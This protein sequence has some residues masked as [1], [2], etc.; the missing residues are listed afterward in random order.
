MSAHCPEEGSKERGRN[1]DVTV[2]HKMTHSLG[3]LIWCLACLRSCIHFQTRR[4]L[5]SSAE[6][7]RW[8]ECEGRGSEVVERTSGQE[9][10]DQERTVEGNDNSVCLRSTWDSFCVFK[11]QL[12]CNCNNQRSKLLHLKNVYICNRSYCIELEYFFCI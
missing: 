2:T 7:K 5:P 11:W 8:E 6:D 3:A 12:F 1:A 10:H 9:P 4:S